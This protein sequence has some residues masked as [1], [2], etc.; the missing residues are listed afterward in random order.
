MDLPEPIAALAKTVNPTFEKVANGLPPFAVVHHTGRTSGRALTTP[1]TAFAGRDPDSA[2]ILT[3]IPLPW[4]PRTDWM[5]NITSAGTF[6]LTRGSERFHV[7]LLRVLSAEEAVTILA[8]L[9]RQLLQT[10]ALEECLVG[11]LR[12]VP[13]AHA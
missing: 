4:G 12:R 8:P 6:E 3:V 1:V 5:R 11:R 2:E 10:L 7:D 9:P 13:S